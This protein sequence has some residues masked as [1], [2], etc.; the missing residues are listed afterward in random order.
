VQNIQR[1]QRD[2]FGNHVHEKRAGKDARGL[3]FSNIPQQ[4][5]VG[6]SQVR[7]KPKGQDGIVR[8]Y[9]TAGVGSSEHQ[10][11]RRRNLYANK[12]IRPPGSARLDGAILPTPSVSSD[13][14][15]RPSSNKSW[16]LAEEEE[17]V[18]DDVRSQAAEYGS[19]STVRKTEWI[20]DDD[21]AK[22]T[23]FQRAKWAEVGAVEHI[24]PNLRNLDNLR[25]YGHA[26]VQDR[27]AAPY[28]VCELKL[29]EKYTQ[30]SVITLITS[31]LLHYKISKW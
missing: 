10:L 11:D 26:T 24:D 8:P 9:H 29:L 22:Y 12:D 6:A 1:T 20:A 25:R 16:K 5:V 18:W 23:N 27:R 3:G 19:T 28:M 13:I 7:S 21:N 17:Y 31:T 14:I 4:P 30:Y 15:N 2:P